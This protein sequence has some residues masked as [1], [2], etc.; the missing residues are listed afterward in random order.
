MHL[1]LT[2][3]VLVHTKTTEGWGQYHLV[4]V[5]PSDSAPWLLTKLV[6]KVV[7]NVGLGQASSGQRTSETKPGTRTLY[8][9]TCC[10]AE[11]SLMWQAHEALSLNTL[12]LPAR[13]KQHTQGL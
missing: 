8:C 7:K 4:W 10:P 12:H 11:G 2:L 9:P 1:R 13:R 3:A 5:A 6:K